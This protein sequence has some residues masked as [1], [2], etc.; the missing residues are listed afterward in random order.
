MNEGQVIALSPEQ[1]QAWL[2]DA[3]RPPPL[4]L[5]VR[6]EWE[7]ELCA[8]DGAKLLP[9]G[10]LQAGCAS[11]DQAREIVCICHHGM[12]S[13]N[14]ACYLVQQGFGKVY[15]LT[16]GVDAWAKRVDPSMPTY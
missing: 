9:L 13:M 11:L 12:R 3:M 7:H 10:L 1:L 8:L 15:N 6:E 4:L 14:A 16:G 2:G 5:D